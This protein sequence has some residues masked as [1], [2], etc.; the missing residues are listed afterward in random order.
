MKTLRVNDLLIVEVEAMEL[1][2]LMLS[3]NFFP[4]LEKDLI[5]KASELSE[6]IAKEHF[7]T[8]SDFQCVYQTPLEV[9]KNLLEANMFDLE[10]TL[11]FKIA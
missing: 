9:F 6:E 11:I 2:K 1:A 7:H 8:E 5:C 3:D 10:S 4:E